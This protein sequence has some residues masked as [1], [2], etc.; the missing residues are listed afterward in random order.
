[1]Y[2]ELVKRLR[3]EADCPD[4]YAEDSCLMREAADAIEQLSNSGSAYGRGWTLGYDAGRKE[5]K[6]PK[7]E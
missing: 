3:E 2:D 5:S 7:E 6:L 1:M 4:N